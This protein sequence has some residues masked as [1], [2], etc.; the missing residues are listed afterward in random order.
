MFIITNLFE[1]IRDFLGPL[2][3]VDMKNVFETFRHPMKYK[4][5]LDAKKVNILYLNQDTNKAT[6]IGGAKYANIIF[7][8]DIR[9]G[10]GIDKNSKCEWDLDGN[11]LYLC[12]PKIPYA[13]VINEN[14]VG[15][16]VNNDP[17]FPALKASF[18]L[19]PH[20]LKVTCDIWATC[21]MT[22]L[23]DAFNDRRGSVVYM[24]FGM[25]LASTLWF[26]LLLL[27]GLL[28]VIFV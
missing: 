3:S 6:I 17:D 16:D 23:L 5:L 26:V 1:G 11:P 8:P 28:M 12:D 22:M 20:L 18:G 15:I 19:P 10:W 14:A 21:G 7:N 24:I 4:K 27:I 25:L 9:K 2:G 13:L